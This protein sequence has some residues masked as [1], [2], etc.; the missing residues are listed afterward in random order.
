MPGSEW[1]KGL[2][3]S[4]PVAVHPSLVH[5]WWPRPLALEQGACETVLAGATEGGEQADAL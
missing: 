2:R 4:F 1:P 5:S 3:F